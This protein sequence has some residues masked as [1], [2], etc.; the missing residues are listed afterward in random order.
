MAFTTWTALRTAIKDALADHIAGKP[1]VQSFTL[2]GGPSFTFR[3]VEEAKKLIE[4]TYQMEAL[5]S[6]GDASVC[7]SYGAY[8]K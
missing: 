2:D 8:R 3:S 4:M 6:A 5:E 1:F 7:V